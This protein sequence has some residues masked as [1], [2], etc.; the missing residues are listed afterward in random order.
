MRIIHVIHSLDPAL[1]GPPVVATRLAAQQALSGHEVGIVTT[2][3]P[4]HAE[5]VAALRADLAGFRKVDVFGCENRPLRELSGFG[6][7]SALLARLIDQRV[8]VHLHGVWDPLIATAA[9]RA[10]RSGGAYGIAPHGMLDPWCL[11]RKRIKKG[12]ALRLGIK[13]MLDDAAFMHVLTES[14][15][16]QVGGVAGRAPA[17]VIPNGVDLP[18]I[19]GKAS[20]PEIWETVPVLRR[21]RY[22]LFLGRL[23]YKKGLD[24]LVS[25]YRLI[26]Q[27]WRDV[28]LVIAGPDFGERA[29]LESR[30]RSLSLA[31]RIHLPGPLYGPAKLSALKHAA[32]F[33]LPSRSEGFSVA[34]VEALACRVPVVISEQ[35][36]FPEAGQAGAGIVVPLEVASL[37]NGLAALLDD[38]RRR[39]TA[40]LAG[41]RL[42]EGRYTWPAVAASAVDA[43]Q[44]Y[45]RVQ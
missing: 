42:V 25:A 40:G 26:A 15:G 36:H 35:C 45:G 34:I 27:G 31:R 30:I 8:F 29:P 19:D 13:R 41:R 2:L 7:G 10:S 22:I 1:G 9:G 43:Y 28:D 44:H 20:G 23:H 21:R 3:S 39:E 11:S 38:P 24:L 16:R 32:C 12:I 6:P 14:E 4:R 18:E 17:V 33:C 37:A 5:R